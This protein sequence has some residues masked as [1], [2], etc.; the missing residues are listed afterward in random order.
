[1][2]TNIDRNAFFGLKNLRKL[3]IFDVDL[4]HDGIRDPFSDLVNLEYLHIAY[5]HSNHYGYIKFDLL[6]NLKWLHLK[7]FD[8]DQD[9]IESIKSNKICVI[10]L[11]SCRFKSKIFINNFQSLRALQ[12]TSMSNSDND[13][14]LEFG[15]NLELM[16]SLSLDSCNL[17]VSQ[18]VFK[19]SSLKFLDLNGNRFES[20]STNLF[21]ELVNLEKL[22]LDIYEHKDLD[23]LQGL[24]SKLYSYY[25]KKRQ[26]IAVSRQTFHK[27]LYLPKLTQLQLGLKDPNLKFL[28]T[29]VFDFLKNLKSLTLESLYLENLGNGVF[30]PLFFLRE[31]AVRGQVSLIEEETFKGLINLKKLD[32]SYNKIEELSSNQ[33]A[34]LKQLEDLYLNGNKIKRLDD[35]VFSRLVS[36]QKLDLWNNEIENIS[37]SAF[38]NLDNLSELNLLNNKFSNN[39][40]LDAFRGLKTLEIIRLDKFSK[41]K[42]EFENFFEKQLRYY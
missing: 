32:L 20:A 6:S 12:L 16:E 1:M 31:L 29:G 37:I 39:I 15:D 13:D 5:T 40:N 3:I 4:N 34:H 8:I 41:D 36:L 26:Q 25:K 30:L 35:W 42:D 14:K 27:N 22:R 24:N 18:S 19:L 10:K 11:D 28:H 33:F 38:E 9:M 17:K 2:D 7:N 21:R 23:V